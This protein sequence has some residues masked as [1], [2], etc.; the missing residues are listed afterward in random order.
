[1]GQRLFVCFHF[2]VFILCTMLICLW[3]FFFVQIVITLQDVYEYGKRFSK[4]PNMKGFGDDEGE[5]GDNTEYYVFVSSSPAL[6][7][8]P[9]PGCPFSVCKRIEQCEGLGAQC[10][11]GEDTMSRRS[12]GEIAKRLLSKTMTMASVVIQSGH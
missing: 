3:T 8:G 5:L 7:L 2:H 4:V 11:V 9:F 6:H 10:R 12:A 1:M